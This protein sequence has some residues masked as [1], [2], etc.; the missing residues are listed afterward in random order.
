MGDI[1]AVTGT[2]TGVGKTYT[3]AL[4]ANIQSALGKRVC[5]YKP[6]QSGVFHDGKRLVLPDIDFIKWHTPLASSDIHV[7]YALNPALSPYHAARE[8]GVGIT[9]SEAVDKAV[10][11]TQTYDT[12]ILEGAGG[13]YAPIL[14]QYYFLDLF[15][16]CGASA[17]VVADGVLG[18]INH[19]LLT[20][21][22]LINRK[23][24]IRMVILNQCRREKEPV[25]D[26]NYEYLSEQ[27]APACVVKLPFIDNRHPMKDGFDPER[28][29][30]I[31][32]RL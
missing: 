20:C 8:M 32:E 17:V 10:Q 7:T 26:I 1:I 15:T 11:L 6:Y 22:A 18:A 5:Y 16:D 27:L 9:S 14:K 25:F 24:K 13:V 23:I 19:T 29:K 31:G 3:A 4:L 2:G 28:F 12:V 30:E 21:E